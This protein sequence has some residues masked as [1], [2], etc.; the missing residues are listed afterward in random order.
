MNYPKD[1]L[2]IFFIALL[3]NEKAIIWLHQNNYLELAAFTNSLYG[4]QKAEDWLLKTNHKSWAMLSRAIKKDSDSLIW[5][6]DNGYTDF[7]AIVG[8]IHEDTNSEQW[9]L[10]NEKF[11]QLKMGELL[12]RNF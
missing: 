7:A 2:N 1:V 11:P 9:L 5:L 4:I 10:K 8:M 12:R 3:R 6:I